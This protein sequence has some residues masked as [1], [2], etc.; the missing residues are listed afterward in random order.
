MNMR[1]THLDADKTYEV[2]IRVKDEAWAKEIVS[3]CND[4][5]TDTDKPIDIQLVRHE[6]Y[7]SS[8]I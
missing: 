8:I 2:I 1:I 6:K 7:A 4:Y 5:F 3:A